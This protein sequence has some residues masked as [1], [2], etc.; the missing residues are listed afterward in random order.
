MTAKGFETIISSRRLGLAVGTRA[1]RHKRNEELLSPAGNRLQSS[2][3]GSIACCSFQTIV[4]ITALPCWPFHTVV[5]I[6]AF[7]CWQSQT[8]V[9]I[10]AFVCWPSQ[11]V[12]GI[13]EVKCIRL[14]CANIAF[15]YSTTAR[16][17]F[18]GL[19]LANGGS[20]NTNYKKNIFCPMCSLL[21]LLCVSINTYE[22]I[23]QTIPMAS[24]MPQQ[25]IFLWKY[26]RTEREY[27]TY[28]RVPCPQCYN[29]E[30]VELLFVPGTRWYVKPKTS[31]PVDGCVCPC[32]L[33]LNC[34]FRCDVVLCSTNAFSLTVFSPTI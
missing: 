27:Q 14:K 25:S 28:C 24:R 10:A 34:L 32:F 17:P 30:H 9:G 18:S 33:Q 3:Y 23:P 16:I 1:L 5:G 13:A 12:V 21:L 6:A 2:R 20:L 15:Y 22:Y 19:H 7:V 8:V 4:S 31:D 29:C 26:Q 11:T